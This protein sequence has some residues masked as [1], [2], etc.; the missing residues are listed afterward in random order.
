MSP[1]R[2]LIIAGSDSGGGAG[3]QADLKT[4]TLLGGFGMTA[5]TAITAQN[6]LGVQGVHPVPTDM[7]LAQM[8][9]CIGDIGVDAVKI[10][11]IGSAQTAAALAERLAKLDNVPIVF[12]PVMV[13]T[14]GSLLADDATVAAFEQLMRIAT[15]ITPNVPELQALTGTT[16]SDLDGLEAAAQ[17]LRDRTG[18]VILAKG[19]HLQQQAQDDRPLIHDL[20]VDEDMVAEYSVERI[21]TRNS[22]G[23]GCTLASAVATGL[24]GGLSLADAVDRAEAF[25]AAALAAAPGLGQGHGPMGHALGMTPFYHLLAARD[26]NGWDAAAFA[27]R[28]SDHA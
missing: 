19:G 17:M 7:V 27:A 6:T 18:A 26:G 5:I 4:V 1:A 23:T 20:L 8:E 12:D 28:Y 14:S 10:G 9:S 21:D 13:A 2:I 11:M 24:G 15:V 16:I 22:H 25:V 3:V